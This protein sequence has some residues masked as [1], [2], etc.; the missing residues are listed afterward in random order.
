MNCELAQIGPVVGSERVGNF[1]DKVQSDKSVV[2]EY[3]RLD[4]DSRK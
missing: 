1:T 2:E 3:F 4:H